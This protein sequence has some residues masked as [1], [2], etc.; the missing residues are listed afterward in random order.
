[1]NATPIDSKNIQYPDYLIPKWCT[2]DDT[3]V[4][5]SKPRIYRGGPNVV[6]I[7]H[8]QKNIIFNLKTKDFN[9]ITG[10]IQLPNH[11]LLVI[12]NEGEKY[13]ENEYSFNLGVLKLPGY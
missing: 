3:L 8:K 12:F 7:V 2:V 9:G 11:L 6:H 4:V 13:G 5:K 10:L 1:M